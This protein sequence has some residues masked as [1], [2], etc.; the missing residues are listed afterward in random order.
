MES[1]AE[2]ALEIA[3]RQAASE[4]AARPEF[5][6]LLL[7]SQIFILGH[8]D[9]AGDGDS[10]LPAGSNL[11]I[12]HWTREDGSQAIPF[13]SSL[14]TL[15]RSIE[16]EQPYIMLSARALFELTQGAALFLNPRSDYG[17]EFFPEEISALLETG[18]SQRPKR[19]LVEKERRVLL[20]QPQDYPAEMVSSLTLLLAKHAR[21]KAAYLA[22]MHE[23]G[24]TPEQS[25][26][27]GIEGEGD[28]D[29]AL[30]EA[31]MVAGDTAP[32]DVPVDITRVQPGD[33]GFSEYFLNSTTP[34][35]ERR[36]GTRLK[37]ALGFLRT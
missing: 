10:P 35:Y 4:P 1:T 33:P 26:V 13:F 22:L 24:A 3:L 36:W 8:S 20:A 37:S 21:V 18:S 14:P 28:L 15:Q 12:V 7:E 27:I 34:F 2:N 25:L 16:G 11:A 30:Q 6:R 19:R 23:P 9:A 31:G 29:A 5:L 17:K 32:R